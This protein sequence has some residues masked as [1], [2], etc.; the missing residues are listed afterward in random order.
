[1]KSFFTY[2]FSMSQSV[3]KACAAAYFARQGNYETA[4]KIMEA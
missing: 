4:K 2:I 1:M 3:S